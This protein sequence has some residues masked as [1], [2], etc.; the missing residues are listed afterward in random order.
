MTPTAD[1]PEVVA[2]G[3]TKRFGS[4][5]QVLGG[6]ELTALAGTMTVVLGAP[7]AGKSTLIRCLAGVYLPDAG[8]VTYRVSS[9]VV[10]LAKAD[11]RTVASMRAHHIASF[12]ELMAA[13]PRLPAAEAAARAA[14]SDRAATIGT[15]TRFRVDDLASVPIGRLR[16]ADRLTVALMATLSA[17]RPFVLLDSPERFADPKVLTGWLRCLTDRGVAVVATGT[18]DSTL[19]AAASAVGQLSEGRIEWHRR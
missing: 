12:D 2:H 4:A 6:I 3:V 15:F 10:D 18:P 16:P 8:G 1:V 17:D 11:A 5:H 13:A 7:G 19:A 14:R 9:E